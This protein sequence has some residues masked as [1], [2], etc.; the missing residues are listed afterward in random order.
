MPDIKTIRVG[1]N[2]V[3]DALVVEIGAQIKKYKTVRVKI[4]KSAEVSKEEIS[5]KIAVRIGARVSNMRG[6]TFTLNK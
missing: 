2:G 4:L 6:H 1:K 3:T 5:A